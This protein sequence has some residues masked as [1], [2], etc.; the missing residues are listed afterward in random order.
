MKFIIIPE[1]EKNPSSFGKCCW[2]ECSFPTILFISKAFYPAK[3]THSYIFKGTDLNATHP[4]M[5][6]ALITGVPLA[7]M[8]V[9][10]CRGRVCSRVTPE[11]APP[12]YPS[13][14]LAPAPP[15]PLSG[16]RGSNLM[17]CCTSRQHPRW[18]PLSRTAPGSSHLWRS[19]CSRQD[20]NLDFHVKY[21]D[22]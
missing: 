16:P 15:L 12:L 4:D 9:W 20:E 10:V 21:L 13:N 14:P 17:G 8:P 22:V 11:C 19:R 7:P 2:T 5:R 18:L 3:L 1:N 6:V